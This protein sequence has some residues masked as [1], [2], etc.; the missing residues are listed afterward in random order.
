MV[1]TFNGTCGLACL[2][3]ALEELVSN[4]RLIQEKRMKLREYATVIRFGLT[5]DSDAYVDVFS[6]LIVRLRHHVWH[7]LG[8]TPGGHSTAV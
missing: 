8:R 7:I 3:G 2:R 4:E 5:S 6:A 1:V